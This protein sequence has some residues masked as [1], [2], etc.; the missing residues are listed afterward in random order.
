MRLSK[1][2]MG[3][4]QFARFAVN[5][6]VDPME[7]AELLTLADRAFKAGERDC[8]EGSDKSGRAYETAHKR[9]GVKARELGFE[10]SWPGLWPQLRRDGHD[11]C[12]PD[13]K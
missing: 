1:R 13:V 3:C 2:M 9:F 8:N 11:I 5:H 12:L 10:V 7:L 4:V 6:S